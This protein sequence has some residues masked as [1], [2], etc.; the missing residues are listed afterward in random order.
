LSDP[1]RP[2]EFLSKSKL[3]LLQKLQGSEKSR[4]IPARESRE[5][6][7]ASFAQE[8]LFFLERLEPGRA[9][10][11]AP[12]CLE[13]RGALDARAL[14]RAIQCI[15]ERHSAL[16]TTFR[17]SDG[18]LV[19]HVQPDPSS[20]LEFVDFSA[21]APAERAERV[22]ALG[23]SEARRPFDLERGPLLRAT[24]VRSS[25]DHHHLFVNMHHIV[26]DA[27]S[28]GLFHR[29]L[30]QNYAALAAGK[31]AVF[32]TLPIDYADFSEWQRERHS[33]GGFDADLAYWAERLAGAPALLELP[34]DRPRPLELVHRGNTRWLELPD[35]LARAL[36]EFGKR[37]GSTLFMVL[38]AGFAVLLR[39][40]TGQR[41]LVVGAPVANRNR[42]ELE[43]LIG[44]FD[45]TL[46]LRID[47]AQNPSFRELCCLVRDECYAGYEHAELPFEKLVEALAPERTLAHTPVFQVA[48]SLEN[49]PFQRPKL[50]GLETTFSWRY[51]ETAKFDLH[52][53]WQEQDG[54]LRGGLEYD[55]DLFD[56]ATIDRWLAHLH[57]ILRAGVRAPDTLIDALPVLTEA[58][59]HALVHDFA[60]G[61]AASSH[62][63]SVLDRLDAVLRRTPDT[64]A[65][66]HERE[67]I[68]Y[69]ELDRRA[70]GLSHALAAR[71]VGP[72]GRVLLLAER[73]IDA[74]VG[75]VAILRA[76]AACVPLDPSHPDERLEQI[77]RTVQPT[78]LLQSRRFAG[79]LG[80]TVGALELE[81]HGERDHGPP[82]SVSAES[83]AYVL[84]TSGST[85]RPKGIE[86][87]HGAL[88]NLIA[89]YLG[90][91]PE[92]TRLLGLAPLSFD[93]SFLEMFFAW[94][95]GGT[96]VLAAEAERSDVA[97]LGRLI[98]AHRVQLLVTP[99]PLLHEFAARWLGEPSALSSL[100]VVIATG[101]ALT[102]SDRVRELF[103]ALPECRL[104]NHYG[105]TETHVVS[106]H[107]LDGDASR[108]PDAPPIGR[109]IAGTSLHLLDTHLEPVPLGAAGEIHV[110]GASV[111][112]GYVADPDGTASSFVPDPFSERPGARLYRTGDLG[113]LRPNGDIEFLGR[114]DGQLKI[115]GFRVEP[116][117]VELALQT[118]PAV[119]RAAVSGSDWKGTRRL[120]AHLVTNPDSS[121]S[122]KELRA[123]LGKLLPDYM[124]PS[125]F[126]L[127]DELPVTSSGKLDRRALPSR[128]PREAR[129]APPI[130]A[131]TGTPRALAELWRELLGVDAISPAD[132][133]F[134]LGGHSILAMQLSNQIE[135]RFGVPWSVVGVFR[136]PILADMAAAIDELGAHPVSRGG[137][138][139]SIVRRA[140]RSV[141]PLSRNQRYLDLDH[142]L[143][144]LHYEL[145]GELDVARLAAAI[146]DVLA[147]QEVLRARF[148][149]TGD[150]LVQTI[151]PH[152]P[153]VLPTL[154][155]SESSSD[156]RAARI[157]ELD[158]EARRPMDL[159]REPAYRLRLLR[160]GPREH[161]LELAIHHLVFDGMSGA[162]FLELVSERYLARMRGSTEPRPEPPFQYADFAAWQ[163]QFYASPEGQAQLRYWREQLAGARALSL[164]RVTPHA[165]SPNVVVDWRLGEAT[166]QR[167]KR[168]AA[169]EQVPVSSVML[170]GFFLVLATRVGFGDIT[171]N[172][173]HSGR[174]RAGTER[175][176][177]YFAQPW[178]LRLDMS[179]PA[180]FR[181][182]VSH[183]KR[184]VAEAQENSDVT[185]VV[186]FDNDRIRFNYL[187][188][189]PFPE[190]D[191]LRARIAVAA[192]EAK[193]HEADLHCEVAELA[194][195]I[196]AHFRY[197]RALFSAR[198]IEVLGADYERLL[199]AHVEAPDGKL[200]RS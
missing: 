107:A 13:L 158:A 128:T 79:R 176:V 114:R 188:L 108:W 53:G 70:N 18:R 161:L 74:L 198:E 154:D 91:F 19:Q 71:G 200:R 169:A 2:A 76:G 36:R 156:A 89:W 165:P 11:N 14:E 72:E 67:S 6:A 98:E 110:G 122:V 136:A 81:D 168:F 45:N 138:R 4:A 97:A 191:E 178:M 69:R 132:D 12:T 119:Q 134:A 5:P 16:R 26:V 120:V 85:G 159:S 93:V 193:P 100:R 61:P 77:T 166:F 24:L 135:T 140:D 155:L 148:T 3:E 15:V 133:F 195:G 126:L 172:T 96:L 52:I 48:F 42:T 73:G 90:R 103:R 33:A 139:A 101:E 113:R 10:Y 182:L 109:P 130:E 181:G 162:I 59:R 66:R 28:L 29:E 86:M 20:V 37:E 105:P 92:P 30:E 84:H 141:H 50:A 164:S 175:L 54:S 131:L 40:L 57:Q 187:P 87:S 160:T 88:A 125:V 9:I 123:H 197:Q 199:D 83:A 177:G 152:E 192:Q 102:M 82:V 190:S 22:Q 104:E 167:V 163:E 173:T 78:L 63:P 23:R 116:R 31:S 143:D 171:L 151:A 39:R 112:R 46:P 146:D 94:C 194:D 51:T 60:R 174:Y 179:R 144:V 115:R 196:L 49:V 35:E 21:L 145:V 99:V 56:E 68:T 65:V 95:G 142:P 170:A 121:P 149:R 124:I 64:I 129:S 44:F 150:T 117:E 147:T 17:L 75:V 137:A 32:P 62:A 80:A 41:E 8:R 127:L 106:A 186:L 185:P 118:H 27:W 153:L 43:G 189:A 25:P 183:V 184:I 111:G 47:V 180:S 1:P 55:T 7:R 34:T 38:L 58:E 157:A